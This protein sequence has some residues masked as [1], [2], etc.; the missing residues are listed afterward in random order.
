MTYALKQ[1][2][3]SPLLPSSVCSVVSRE[4][5]RFYCIFIPLIISNLLV[6]LPPPHTGDK[7]LILIIPQCRE[8]DACLHPKGNFCDKQ[9]LVDLS[10]DLLSN[11]SHGMCLMVTTSF[12][13]TPY[14]CACTW[15]PVC[16][17]VQQCSSLLWGDDGRDLPIF[18]PRTEDLSLFPNKLIHR[19][20]CGARVCSGKN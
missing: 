2:Q 10:L 18:L 17:T 14:D 20:H 9:E 4:W 16:V 8:C 11:G 1:H 13:S 3:M 7:A 12:F 19:V 15:L 5:V 6:C